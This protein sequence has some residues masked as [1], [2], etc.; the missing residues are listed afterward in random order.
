MTVSMRERLSI[1]AFRFAMGLSLL[2]GCSRSAVV[3]GTEDSTGHRPQPIASNPAKGPGATA[4]PPQQQQAP[5]DVAADV[6]ASDREHPPGADRPSPAPGDCDNEGALVE[7]AWSR[8]ARDPEGAAK[9]FRSLCDIDCAYGCES[10]GHAYTNGVGVPKS[11][12][13]AAAAYEKT[14]DLDPSLCD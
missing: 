3:P 12:E 4:A 6:D 7:E 13:L 2:L 14:C 8:S 1:R 10:L 11:P 5:P 9:V